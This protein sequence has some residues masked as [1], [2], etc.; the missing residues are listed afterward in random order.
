M[1]VMTAMNSRVVIDRR[2][3]EKLRGNGHML[4]LDSSFNNGIVE[5]QAPLFPEAIMKRQYEIA[6]RRYGKRMEVCCV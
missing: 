4:V 5:V 2:G 1:K 3:G 6:K